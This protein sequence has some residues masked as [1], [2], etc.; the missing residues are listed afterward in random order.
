M[1]CAGSTI[2]ISEYLKFRKKYLPFP[3]T[4][5]ENIIEELWASLD[6]HGANDGVTQRNRGS[7]LKLKTRELSACDAAALSLSSTLTDSSLDSIM[8]SSRSNHLTSTRA[9]DSKEDDEV[10]SMQFKIILLGDGAVGKVIMQNLMLYSWRLLTSDINLLQGKESY[11]KFLRIFM[12]FSIRALTAH[13]T[14]TNISITCRRQLQ[15][16]SQTISFLKI[17]SKL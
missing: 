15:R 9:A 8:S 6:C 10:R 2:R 1:V 16:D 13:V 17:T 14:A 5:T 7:A 11:R 3:D 12:Y 4:R